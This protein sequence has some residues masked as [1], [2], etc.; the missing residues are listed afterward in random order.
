MMTGKA[1]IDRDAF[2]I[3]PLFVFAAIIIVLGAAL[4]FLQL[5]VFRGAIGQS[6]M[7]PI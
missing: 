7:V 3:K 2:A 1:D 5:P 6:A 4:S